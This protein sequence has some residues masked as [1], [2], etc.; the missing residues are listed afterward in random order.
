MALRIFEQQATALGRLFT[1]A[2]NFTDPHAYFVGGGAVETT[3]EFRDWFLGKV[4]EHTTL[5]SEQVDASSIAV[6][7]DRDM[8]GARGAALSAYST[9]TRR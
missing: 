5:R 4:R 1:V 7:P 3:P 9:L 8:A 2:A 6:V